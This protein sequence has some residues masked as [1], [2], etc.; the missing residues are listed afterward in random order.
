M[1]EHTLQWHMQTTQKI[2]DLY[3]L[4]QSAL[5]SHAQ[6]ENTHTCTLVLRRKQGSLRV[7]G[8]ETQ[9]PWDWKPYSARSGG[10]S[11]R[12]KKRKEEELGSIGIH[13]RIRAEV[14]GKMWQRHEDD[15][16]LS[17]SKLCRKPQSPGSLDGGVR[18][19]KNTGVQWL[20]R[21]KKCVKKYKV[22][23]EG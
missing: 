11:G 18:G 4:T 10:G 17:I 22:N 5:S 12:R 21:I 16:L 6:I 14:R 7:N 2:T 20:W 23:R 3:T 9:G 19:V 1:H 8:V 13:M 15:P